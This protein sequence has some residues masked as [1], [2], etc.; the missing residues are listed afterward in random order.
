MLK[1]QI[2]R[3][4]IPEL[5][6]GGP[7]HFTNPR[8]GLAEAG[9]F[10][11][12]FGSSHRS[13]VRVA[14]VSTA[15]AIAPVLH[16]FGRCK[17]PI[18]PE[19]PAGTVERF[20]GFAE[21]FRSDLV[22]DE[23]SAVCIDDTALK[24][25]LALRPYD[26][27]AKVVDLYSDA[28]TRA[29]R[30]FLP[31]VIVCFI[32]DAVDKRCHSVQR[33]MTSDEKKLIRSAAKVAADAQ[34]ELPFD[35]E[36]DEAPEDLL[37]RDLR[38]ALKAR[39]MRIEVPIQIVTNNVLIDSRENEEAC[40][41]AW[42]LCVGMYYKAGGVPW[43]VRN[44]G[45]ET[46]YVGITF[47]HLRTTKRALVHSALAQAFST[48]GGGF[49]LRGAALDSS[50]ERARR[51]PNMSR[52]QTQ[53]LG[54]RVLDAYIERNGTLPKRVV[55][56]KS[57]RF[58]DE[59]RAGF[60]M[61]LNSVP[62][63]QMLSITPSSVRLVTHASYPPSRGTLL[64]V[65]D[66]RH[67][68]FTSGYVKDL[69]TYPGPHIPIPVEIIMHGEHTQADIREAAIEALGLG[70]L[71][72]NTSDLRSSQPV[73]LGFARRVGGIMAEYGLSDEREPDPNYRYYM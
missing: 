63:V 1:L 36:P 30:E 26:A 10:D 6:F 59:E 71:N 4:P 19:N 15:D 38:R 41:R 58:T 16:W 55:L 67:F 29:K 64:T 33:S 56:H 2:A 53:E 18:E 43:R 12:R 17:A 46:C 70:R 34:M 50:D 69:E 44:R 9:P 68:L 73:T 51:S 40:L 42:N 65:E 20:P 23:K 3:L 47:H 72:W 54:R 24:N 21:V 52:S 5:E 28:M 60:E 8:K 35:W 57:S 62:V 37:R 25:A 14:I 45:P 39:A 31:D 66:A 7:G 22:I 11:L 49:A 32:P 13:Q 61:A 27:L 48:N